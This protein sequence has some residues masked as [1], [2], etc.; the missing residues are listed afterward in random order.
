M[1]KNG[2]YFI[3]F[4]N[5]MAIAGA[6]TTNINTKAT[7]IDKSSPQTGSWEQHVTKRKGWSATTSYL[8]LN[9]SALAVIGATGIQDLLQAGNSFVITFSSGDDVGVTG[10]ATLTDVEITANTCKLVTGTFKF[11][12]NGP[13]TAIHRS[14]E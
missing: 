12:G 9:T 13:L 14:L 6:K 4:A 7:T 2:K 10:T 5:G 1:A 8:V 3:L 11:K